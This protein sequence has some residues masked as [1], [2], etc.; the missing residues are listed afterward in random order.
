MNVA[1]SLIIAHAVTGG[2]ALLGGLIA[3]ISKKGSPR[4]KVTGKVFYFAMLA[5]AFVAIIVANMPDHESP[6]LLSIGIFTSYFLLGGRRAISYKNKDL[7][8]TPDKIITYTM[9]LCGLAMVAVPVIINRQLNIIL[10]VFGI[11]GLAFAIR[12]LLIFRNLDNLKKKRLQLHVGKMMGGYISATTAFIVVNNLMQP[13]LLNWFL[14]SVFGTIYIIYWMNKLN[15]KSKIGV[16]LL[17]GLVTANTQVVEAQVYTEKQTRHRF[18][19]LNTGIDFQRSI[20]GSTSYLEN[21]NVEYADLQ[22]LYRPRYIIGGTHFWGHADFYVAIPLTNPSYKENNREIHFTNGVETVF[23]YYPARI[24]HNQVRPFV[25][26]S[27]SPFTYQQ[28][29]FNYKYPNGP[30]QT[31][32]R[33]PIL[34]GLTFNTGNHLIDATLTYNYKNQIDYPITPQMAALRSVTTP[35]LYLGISY[36]YMMETTLSAEKDWESGATETVTK[37]LEG[38]G[39]LNTWFV[40]AGMSSAWWLG[41]SEYNTNYR[42]TIANYG[43]SVMP[44]FAVGYYLHKP[45]MNL[46]FNYRSYGQNVVAYNIEQNLSRRSFGFEITKHLFD[47]HGFVPFIGPVVSHEK[48]SFKET[49]NDNHPSLDISSNRISAG[50]TFGWDIRPNRLQ[51]FLLRTNLRYYPSLLLNTPTGSSVS[52]NNL[53]FNFIQ[54]LIFPQRIF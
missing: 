6:F 29:D 12:D 40:A 31:N 21:G 48:L 34:T 35:P 53:E 23:K 52:F 26:L 28:S 54:L 32:V 30:Y 36:R 14:P 42:P 17:F 43:I 20:G 24:E 37:L 51:W 16:F 44:D 13:V 22:P 15:G 46:V 2:V 5:S 3:L 27:I 4:H 50:I 10:S 8:L 9:I 49:I 25:G 7:N 19:Q 47:Y 41:Q 38:S 11:V 45:D 33:V 39:R 18:A 1:D